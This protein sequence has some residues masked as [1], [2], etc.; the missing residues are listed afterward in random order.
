MKRTFKSGNNYLVLYDCGTAFL[1]YGDLSPVECDYYESGNL[2]TIR[3]EGDTMEMMVEEGSISLIMGD[4]WK[5][6]YPFEVA[7]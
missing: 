3:L 2:I 7:L 1:R 4:K 6:I 5:E